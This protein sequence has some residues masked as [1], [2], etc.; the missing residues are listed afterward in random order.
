MRENIYNCDHIGLYTNRAKKLV[1]FYTNKLMFKKVKEE[2]LSKSIFKKIFGIPVDCHFI[3]L[4]SD[5]IMLEIFEPIAKLASKRLRNSVG[6]NHW[7]YCVDDRKRFVQRL[8]RRR[9]KVTE[10]KRNNHIV[11]KGY[12][13]STKWRK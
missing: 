11:H 6:L 9:V 10:I 3:R 5:N 12:T 8:R 4:I 2:I 7:G 1:N 13:K